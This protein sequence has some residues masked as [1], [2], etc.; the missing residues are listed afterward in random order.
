MKIKTLINLLVILLI[1]NNCSILN[2]NEN[3]NDSSKMLTDIALRAQS[4]VNYTLNSET[5]CIDGVTTS[6]DTSLPS[7]IKDN[8]KCV[9]VKVSGS[10]Y[11]F[12]ATNLPNHK[13]FYYGY[14]NSLYEDLPSGNTPAGINRISAQSITI[15]V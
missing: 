8:F 4:N 5:G 3:T 15:T 14:G 2:K 7:W 1:I 10:N 6:M 13:S 11:V 9:T 12:T